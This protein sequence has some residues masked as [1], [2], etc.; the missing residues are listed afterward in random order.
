MTDPTK[1]KHLA[2]YGTL[3][4][5]HANHGVADLANKS[6]SKGLHRIPGVMYAV[7]NNGY[8]GVNYPGAI[9]TNP[10]IGS[11]IEVELLEA[12]V[13]GTGLQ[14][15]LKGLDEFE[16]D[17]DLE[18]EY[19]RIIVNVA[20]TPA[21]FYEYIGDVKELPKVSKGVW[22]VDIENNAEHQL[23][24]DSS[25]TYWICKLC[26]AKGLDGEDSPRDIAC[27]AIK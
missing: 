2:V 16:N 27:V 17:P 5:G 6:I 18:P 23:T 10:S 26:G 21:W 25:F 20:G 24:F 19:A 3:R 4:S 12:T 11:T 22:E 14:E 1:I 15:L 7:P 13:S 9:T 8:G